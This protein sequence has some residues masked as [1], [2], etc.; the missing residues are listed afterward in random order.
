MRLVHYLNQLFGG[1]GGEDKADLPPETRTG[2][3]GPGR[4]LEQLLGGDSQ[5]VAT[6]ICGDNYAA[7]NLPAV[8]S[9]VTEAVENAQDDLVVAGPCFQAGRYGT[10][11]GAVCAAVQVQLGVPGIT[12]MALENPGVDL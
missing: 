11:A 12:A 5:V 4:M 9:A 7:E 10:A 3:V 1:L 2:A 8:A 6:I